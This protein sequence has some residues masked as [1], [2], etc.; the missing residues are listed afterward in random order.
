LPRAL[1]IIAVKIGEY[2]PKSDIKMF[3]EIQTKFKP[4][5]TFKGDKAFIGGLNISTPYKK[6]KNKKLTEKQNEEN[7]IFSGNR[8]FVEHIIRMVKIFRIGEQRFRLRFSNYGRVMSVICGLVRLRIEAF[9][10]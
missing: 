9:I 4:N 6:S 7:K 10:L 5:Q 3:R 1:D 8:V 2:G